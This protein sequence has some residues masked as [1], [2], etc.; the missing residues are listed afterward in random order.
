MGKKKSE[1]TRDRAFINY[2]KGVSD[3]ENAVSCGVSIHSIESWKRIFGWRIRRIT[4]CLPPGTKGAYEIEDAIIQGWRE[5]RE[6]SERTAGSRSGRRRQ[7]KTYR[8]RGS[9]A[10]I[11]NVDKGTGEIRKEEKSGKKEEKSGKIGPKFRARRTEGL[12]AMVDRPE[13]KGPLGE[14]ARRPHYVVV[15]IGGSAKRMLAEDVEEA[16]KEADKERLKG[17]YDASP[18]REPRR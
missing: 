15:M 11:E 6:G 1:W 16:Q 12:V 9:G 4:S 3:Y 8:K 7:Q 10:G 13:E 17:W 2:C 14:E 5:D 18:E